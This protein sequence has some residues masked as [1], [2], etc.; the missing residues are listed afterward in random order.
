MPKKICDVCGQKTD[1]YT[2]AHRKAP[3]VD[4]KNYA[5]VCFTCYFVPKTTEQ[6]YGKDG[7]LVEERGV[8]YSPLNLNAAR[9]LLDQGAAD[10][11]S[12]AQKCVEAV[13]RACR[14]VRPQK[15]PAGPPEPSWNVC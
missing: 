15:K 2:G 3:F 7:G 14:G 12:Y 4:G 5:A 13:S 11:L 6:E 9:D 1:V 10:T 8:P